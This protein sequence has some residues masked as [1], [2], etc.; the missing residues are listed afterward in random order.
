MD[1][2]RERSSVVMSNLLESCRMQLKLWGTGLYSV[3]SLFQWHLQAVHEFSA[4]ESGQ[5]AL[6]KT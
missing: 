3:S 2:D 5:A 4:L 1:V 6:G